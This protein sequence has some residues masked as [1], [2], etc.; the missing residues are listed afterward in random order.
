VGLATASV[1]NLLDLEL[2]VVAG[3]VALGFGAPFFE[4]A[5]EELARSSRLSFVTGARI[6]AAG[7][8][9]SGPL[10]GAGAVGW[11]GMGRDIGIAGGSDLVPR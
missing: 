2:T 4:A 3:S 6:E 1:S 7:L 11:R 8:G 10:I 5:S 9:A